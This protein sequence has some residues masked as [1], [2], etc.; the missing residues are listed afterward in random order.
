VEAARVDKNVMVKVDEM[1]MEVS[2]WMYQICL[3]SLKTCFV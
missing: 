3:M 2:Q 1:L